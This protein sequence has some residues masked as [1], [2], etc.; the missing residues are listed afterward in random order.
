MTRGTASC[1]CRAATRLQRRI[2]LQLDGELPMSA[3]RGCPIISQNGS[4]WIISLMT[5]VEFPPKRLRSDGAALQV[6]AEKLK[7]PY[8][9]CRIHSRGSM[10]AEGTTNTSNI[11]VTLGS[12]GRSSLPPQFGFWERESAPQLV[13]GP[14]MSFQPTPMTR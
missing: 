1:I 2:E 10:A 6:N 4:I 9:S 12:P 5:P 8:L 11:D 3:K 13:L 7:A 14:V